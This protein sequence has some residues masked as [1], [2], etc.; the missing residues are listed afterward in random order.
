MRRALRAGQNRR[1][2]LATPSARLRLSDGECGRPD[3][4]DASATSWPFK[5]GQNEGA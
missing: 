5:G 3:L 4:V 2:A 1:F